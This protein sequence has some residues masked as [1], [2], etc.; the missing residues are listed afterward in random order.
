MHMALNGGNLVLRVPEENILCELFEDYHGKCDNGCVLFEVALLIY[1]SDPARFT[2]EFQDHFGIQ[3]DVHRRILD[4]LDSGKPHDEIIGELRAY[5]E[6][7]REATDPRNPCPRFKDL[8][9]AFLSSQDV[10][11]VHLNILEDYYEAQQFKVRRLLR[12]FGVPIHLW[13]LHFNRLSGRIHLERR[14]QPRE[15]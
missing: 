5:S 11:Y 7:F 6:T 10:V 13:S 9:G 8:V 2:R 15:E 4:A 1:R 3:E 12:F 14:V